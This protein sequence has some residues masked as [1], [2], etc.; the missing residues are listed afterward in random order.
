MA[1]VLIFLDVLVDFTRIPDKNT[2]HAGRKS[3]KYKMRKVRA[4]RISDYACITKAIKVSDCASITKATKISDC[5]CITK[6]TKVS[7]CA[8]I[9]KANNV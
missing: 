9:T 8:C 3:M 1:Y 2:R 7:E 5:A 6:A 4:K